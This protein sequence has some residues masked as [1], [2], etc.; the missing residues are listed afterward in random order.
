MV[1]VF[2]FSGHFA[3]PGIARM[4]LFYLTIYALGL[5]YDAGTIG[6]MV[7]ALLVL[8]ILAPLAR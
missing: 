1:E 2:R 5:A 7:A 8:V 3:K 4:T 6:A